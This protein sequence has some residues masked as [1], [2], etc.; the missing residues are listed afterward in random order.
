MSNAAFIEKPMN[1]K[2]LATILVGMVSWL[3]SA[4]MEAQSP[5]LFVD[6]AQNAGVVAQHFDGGSPKNYLP[7]L[8]MTGLALFDFDG[9]GW[10]DIY[11]LNGYELSPSLE[12]QTA[13]SNRKGNTL[14]RN[15]QDGT[16][17]DVTLAAGVS[18]GSFAMG[19]VSA[20]FDNDGDQDLITSNFGNIELYINNGDGTFALANKVG[21]EQLDMRFGS[22]IAC[23]DID[24]DGLLDIFASNYVEFSYDQ[25]SDAPRSS[26]YP[27][28]PKDFPPASDNLYRNLG[29]GTFADVSISSGIAVAAGPSMGVICGDF[30]DDDDADI[31]VCSDAAPNQFFVNDGM[32][33]FV[34][35]ALVSGLAFDLGGN[36][37]GSMGVDAGDYDN[38]GRIDLLITNYT[39]QTPVMY[40]HAGDGIFEDKSR[41]SRVGSTVLAHTN[42]GVGLVDFDN[43]RDLDVLFANGHFLKNIEAIDDRTSYRVPNT[44][45]LNDG[46]GRFTDVSKSSGP[47]LEISESSRGAG[48]E[49]FDRDGD[50]D[51][52]LLNAN[53][54]PTLLDNQTANVGNWINVR[55]IGTS[56][57]R[58][59]I[60][61]RVQVSAGR[62][63]QVA[64]VHAG[65]GYQSHYGTELHFGLGKETQVDEIFVTWPGGARE[66]FSMEET[67]TTI[68]LLQGS[69]KQFAGNR[70]R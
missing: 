19:A 37:N 62:S 33:H 10:T 59:A 34:D 49:D 42:W 38:D 4:R 14:Y 1:Q 15:N 41:L 32:G 24:S 68:R 16:F 67:C 29:D 46:H 45:M 51:C 52:V 50:I 7:Q 69:G 54:R 5:F 12:K 3:L 65:R 40:R 21:L 35:Q 27:P 8:M 17:S 63:K 47:G 6:Q 26:P 30:D 53:S 22:G 18:S 56:T 55:L 20:D 28:G 31:F 23:L 36:A 66:A 25:Y 9:D 57:N 2:E 64:M 60:G 39:G 43:D 70:S 61:A 48:F 13:K 44:V 11:L 58:D